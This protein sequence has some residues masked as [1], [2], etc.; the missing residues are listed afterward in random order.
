M[1]FLEKDYKKPVN[2]NYMRFVEGKN[3]F[4]VL[5][6]AITGWEY[7]TTKNKPIRQADPFEEMPDDIKTNKFGKQ[8]I[9]H[10]WAFVVW[11]YNAKKVQ[12]LELTQKG[13][14]NAI[15]ALINEP[16]WGDPQGYDIVVTRIN[17]E[18]TEYQTMATPHSKKPE[19][20]KVGKI[21]LEAILDGKDPFAV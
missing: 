11:N 19:E 5:S 4:R 8:Q 13:I 2:S 17:G 18:K 20:A 15:T 7:W 10:F 14:M 6:D 16:D 9:N 1:S 12:I 21:N 3:K